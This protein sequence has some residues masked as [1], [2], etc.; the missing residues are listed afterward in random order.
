MYDIR[1]YGK[2]IADSVRM[3]AYLRALRLAVRPGS[4]VLDIGTG[5]GI[6]ALLACRLGARR[7]YAAEPSDAI[8]VAR[9]IASANGLAETIEFIQAPSTEIT[10]PEPAHV[11]ISDLRGILP[12]HQHHLTAIIDARRRLLAPGGV[13]IPQQDTLWLACVEAPDMH[14]ELAAPWSGD[15]YGID[16]R[17]ASWR[18]SNVWY[19]AHAH[20]GQMLTAPLCCGSI[21]YR[22]AEEL[23]LSA[24]VTSQPTRAGTAHGFCAWFDATLA[25]G[26][27]IC[28]A[29]DK[30]ELIYGRAF[31]PWPEPVELNV[32]DAMTITLKANLVGDDYVWSWDTRV[33]ARGDPLHV[34]AEF[35]QST[36]FGEL[37]APSKLRQQAAGHVPMLSDDGLIA[38]LVLQ[39]MGDA[40]PLGDIA[41]H[42][43]SLHPD[44]FPR[45]QDA[46]T[47]VGELSMRYAK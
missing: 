1:A 8:H 46:L 2:M 29:L 16:M 4:V 12:L 38:R 35:K 22:T 24:A 34:K 26:I 47:R 39:M 10:L 9:E 25:E 6:F 5:T 3:E 21:D 14:R 30:P 44:R 23:D 33:L 42:L 37:E 19:K 15:A 13:L 45:W 32:D 40:V 11:I 43:A 31:F 36:F 20:P 18:A 41:R 17:A 27:E 7:V 28:N